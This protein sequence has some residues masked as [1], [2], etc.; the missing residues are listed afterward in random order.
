MTLSDL[1]YEPYWGNETAL[2]YRKILGDTDVTLEINKETN[3]VTKFIN[4]FRKKIEVE[5]ES[6][7]VILMENALR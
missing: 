6:M 7:E 2:S 4:D 5:P 3:K 1:G